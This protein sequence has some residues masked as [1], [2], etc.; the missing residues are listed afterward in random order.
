MNKKST[1]WENGLDTNNCKGLI[2][3]LYKELQFSNFKKSFKKWT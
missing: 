3:R 2:F 1:D